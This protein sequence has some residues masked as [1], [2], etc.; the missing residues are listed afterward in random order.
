[1]WLIFTKEDSILQLTMAAE[2]ADLVK[3]KQLQELGSSDPTGTSTMQPLYQISENTVE[4]GTK[5]F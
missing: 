2:D 3:M 4:A 5:R 1:M